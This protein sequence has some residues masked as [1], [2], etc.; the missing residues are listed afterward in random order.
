MA[1]PSLADDG[2]VVVP[3]IHLFAGAKNKTPLRKGGSS[4][5]VQVAKLI[6]RN[7]PKQ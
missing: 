4:Q 3:V 1:L 5:H 7:N 6:V 2:G